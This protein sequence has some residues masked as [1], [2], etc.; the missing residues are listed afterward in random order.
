VF[1]ATCSGAVD[2]AGNIALPVHATYKV[3]YGFMGFSSPEPGSTVAR[4]SRVIYVVFGLEGATGR[5]V[6][7]AAGAA[8]AR[9]H[10]VRATLRGPSIK[11]V[12]AVCAWHATGS[13]FRCALSIPGGV[14]TRASARYTITAYENPG[15]G[16]GFVAA[17]GEPTAADPETIRFSG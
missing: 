15:A 4:S 17:P 7:G 5:S 8:L 9:A 12:T 1:T 2:L 6:S 16:V 13:Y 14:S 10:D 11:P 3:G